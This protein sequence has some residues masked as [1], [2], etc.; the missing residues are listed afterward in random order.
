M[1]EQERITWRNP[2]FSDWQLVWKGDNASEDKVW[3]VHRHVLV[4]GS[5]AAQF[6]AGATREGA[7]ESQSTD[8]AKLLPP[9]CK[10]HMDRTLDFIYGEP[11]GECGPEDIAPLM[12]IAD[13]MQCPKLH[14]EIICS[15]DNL[16]EQPGSVEVMLEGAGSMNL[17]SL[18]E[19]LVTLLPIERLEKL[20]FKLLDVNSMHLMRTIMGRMD[21]AR[22][23]RWERFVGHGEVYGSHMSLNPRDGDGNHDEIHSC[24][25]VSRDPAQVQTQTWKIRI[26]KMP[27]SPQPG[28]VIGVVGGKLPESRM[29][30]DD[31]WARS[32][33]YIRFHLTGA[34]VALTRDAASHWL[35][36]SS[37]GNA[38]WETNVREILLP[39]SRIHPNCAV[40]VKLVYA[41][42]DVTK[43]IDIE[44]SV[45][46]EVVCRIRE[47]LPRGPYR[48]FTEL[49]CSKYA[50]HKFGIS[51]IDHIKG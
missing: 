46:D 47:A 5:R 22:C 33:S 26:D 18:A 34:C 37:K 31:D 29:N 20:D 28:I 43:D 12:K 35:S 4:G 7:Y 36:F 19:A 51:L 1:G 16:Y 48:L 6:F 42:S 3:D 27:E 24:F 15:L 41:A 13:V 38:N 30:T 40:G 11:L 14:N 50:P 45:N 23:L 21:H 25:A 9:M 49:A 8:L 32:Q 10:V 17:P 2:R 44:W 39:E